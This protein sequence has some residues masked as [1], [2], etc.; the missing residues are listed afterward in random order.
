MYD[1]KANIDRVATLAY[2]LETMDKMA[3]V[4]LHSRIV[5]TEA[6]EKSSSLPY[7]SIEEFL[8]HSDVTPSK[9]NKFLHFLCG[10]MSASN[11]KESSAFHLQ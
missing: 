4:A 6:F 1:T 9:L 10:G 3:E 7:P 2:E 8:L 5:V 11:L